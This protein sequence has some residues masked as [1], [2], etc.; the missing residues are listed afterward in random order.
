[1][2]ITK[3][4]HIK[5]VS[6]LSE[7]S[8]SITGFHPPFRPPTVYKLISSYWHYIGLSSEQIGFSSL[9]LTL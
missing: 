1:M 4:S 9:I 7:Y 2:K 3:L 8:T 5:L 6:I